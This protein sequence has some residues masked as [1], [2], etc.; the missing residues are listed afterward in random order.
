VGQ[1]ETIPVGTVCSTEPDIDPVVEFLTTEETLVVG[2][3]YADIPV[4]AKEAGESGNVEAEKVTYLPQ[5][6]PNIGEI[7][8]LQPIA[9]GA[10]EE[11]DES[12][13][14]RIVLRWY[15]TSFGGCEESFRTWALE[16]D[17]VA[18]ARAIA[19]WKGPGTVK[20]YIWSKDESNKLVPASDT[21]ISTVQAY[22]DE[23]KP[24]CTSVTVGKPTG[25][26]VDVF[27]HLECESG[28][29][30]TTVSENVRSA[31]ISFFNDLGVGEDLIVSKLIAVIM[32]EDGV[33]DAK[34]GV[35]KANVDCEST[36][37][38]MLG[39]SGVVAKSWEK[40]YVV[41]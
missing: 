27:V 17:G 12:L 38:I 10:D 1:N 35:P 32:G 5:T 33:K 3:S 41:W 8:N 24:I 15:G 26:L 34:I 9:G 22:I 19:C 28:Y 2:G 37:T 6:F 4:E 14:K 36:D 30:F 40:Q 16:V 11:D 31:I 13:R 25:I 29:A 39:R 23:R 20:I 21:L 18:E 7:K